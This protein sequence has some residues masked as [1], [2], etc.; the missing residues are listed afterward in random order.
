MANAPEQAPEPEPPYDDEPPPDDEEFPPDLHANS[1]QPRTQPATQP[2]AQVQ[3]SNPAVGAASVAR[4]G[5]A[6]AEKQRYGES[7]VREI[8]GATFLEEQ[9]HD[10]A[11]RTRGD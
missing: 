6:F 2:R 9:P 3:A 5:P 10:P 11:S 1:A 7:V 8:L 4:R